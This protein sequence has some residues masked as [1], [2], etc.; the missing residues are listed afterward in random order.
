MVKSMIKS[1][2]YRTELREE[3]LKTLAK[4]NKPLSTDEIAS[5]LEISWHTAIRHC[6]YLELEGKVFKFNIGRI[7]A[8]QIKK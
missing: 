1:A 6:L 2:I 4:S 5:F 8:W 7:S 3:I